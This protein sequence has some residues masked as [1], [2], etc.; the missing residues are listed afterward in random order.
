MKFR[1]KKF[2]INAVTIFPQA[3]EGLL[4][5]SIIGS[6]RKKGIPES[7][8]V[9]RRAFMM[10]TNNARAWSVKASSMKA[11]KLERNIESFNL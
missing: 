4:D 7:Q 2:L 10:R 3:F 8:R 11:K 9:V 5:V 6:A 1:K